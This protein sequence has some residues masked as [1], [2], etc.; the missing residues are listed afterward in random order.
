MADRE[1][2]GWRVRAVMCGRG[3]GLGVVAGWVVV[4]VRTSAKRLRR[5]L[6]SKVFGRF[7]G[8]AVIEEVAHSAQRSGKRCAHEVL[9]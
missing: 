6:P 1:A 7:A 4:C 9:G 2:C 5:R 3:E 8:L